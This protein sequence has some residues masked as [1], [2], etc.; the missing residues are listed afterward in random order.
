MDFVRETPMGRKQRKAKRPRLQKPAEP[1]TRRKRDDLNYWP[2]LTNPYGYR[3]YFHP[4]H[5]G[6]G[7]PTDSCWKHDVTKSEE[8]RI[9]EIGAQLDLCDECGNLYNVQGFGRKHP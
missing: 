7:K 5:H 9:F 1:P 6:A 3:Y 2:H 8:F 4:K